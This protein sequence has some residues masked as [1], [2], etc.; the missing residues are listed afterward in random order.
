MKKIEKHEIES[1]LKVEEWPAISIYMPVSRIGDQQDSIRYKNCITEVERRLINMGMRTTEARTLLE[2]EYDLV[3]DAEYWKNLGQDGMVV[4]LSGSTVLRYSLPV[5]FNEMVMVGRRFHV[6]PLLPLLAGR[7]YLV[8][9]LSGNRLQ[10][11]QG[12]RFQLEEIDLPEDTPRSMSDVLQ[13]DDPER[14]LQFHTKT[15]TAGGKRG[16]MFHGQGVGIDDQ[17][18][19]LE[20][21]FQEVDR[22]LFPLLEDG[23]VP[24]ILAGTEELHACYRGITRSHT[25]LPRG[26][27]GNVS[28]LSEEIL[29]QKAWDIAGDYFSEQEQEVV[30]NFQD[31]LGSV[32]VIDDL[33]S[34][35]TAAF[36]GR[37]EVLF[38][39]ENEQVWGIFDREKRQVTVKKQDEGQ[40]VNLL[41]EAVF[42]T[43]DKKG[44]VHVKKNDDMPTNSIVSAQLRY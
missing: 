17:N 6:R 43:F 13:Y 41:D 20:R 4:F 27:A 26:I 29:H 24:I 14:Q 42:L 5:S 9:A 8:L 19:N 23:R 12:D 21:Y 44:A 11:F 16:A 25:I 37:I 34:V 36:D 18:H 1:L 30:R 28:E 35:L 38:V 40:V 32:K 15:G 10:L 31:N 22:S 2:S 3:M 33:E 7:P 39:A